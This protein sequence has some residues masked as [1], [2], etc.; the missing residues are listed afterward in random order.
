[1]KV[2]VFRRSDTYTNGLKKVLLD[3]VL[4]ILIFGVI[5]TALSG[6]FLFLT[7]LVIALSFVYRIYLYDL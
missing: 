7:A 5:S 3:V 6:M 4:L 2:T 1:M